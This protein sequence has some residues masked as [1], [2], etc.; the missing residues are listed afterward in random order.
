MRSKLL[1]SALIGLTWPLTH[2]I[3]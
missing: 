3:G 2:W 1:A